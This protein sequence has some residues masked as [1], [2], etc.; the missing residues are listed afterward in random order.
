MVRCMPRSLRKFGP[1]RWL[2]QA[3]RDVSHVLAIA[4]MS[5]LGAV[6]EV[7]QSSAGSFLDRRRRSRKE[8]STALSDP[9][10]DISQH[11]DLYRIAYEEGQRALDDQTDEL[12]RLRDRAVQFTAFI[13]AATAFLVGAGIHPAHRDSVFYTLAG[14]A[15]GLS[16]L[17]ILLLL[18]LLKPR[19][20]KLWH[21]P[22]S[23]TSL[24]VGWIETEVPLPSEAHFLRALA[25]KYDTMR[26]QNE[27]LL[28]VLRT[29]YTFLIIIGAIQI[30]FWA[31]LVWVTA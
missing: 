20:R 6:S 9:K 8:P 7:E 23:A 13:G 10:G 1:H 26:V 5:R 12:N 29:T 14:T 16:I 24:I 17:S 18:S 22:L 28:G 4:R 2:S 11:I 25:E 15:S 30:T 21:Y 3:G 31:A 19:T 27:L